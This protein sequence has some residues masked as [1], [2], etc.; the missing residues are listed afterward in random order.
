MSR[1]LERIVTEDGSH[2]LYIPSM[3]ETYHSTH[4]AIQESQHVFVRHG[5]EN[6][7]GLTADDL[8]VFEVGFGTGLNA[9]LTAAWAA[10]NGLTV[11]MTSIE[12]YPVEEEIWNNL[13]YPEQLDQPEAGAWWNA[14]HSSAWNEE[15][16][17]HEHFYLTKLH[18]KLEDYSTHSAFADVI[19][20]DA[21][22]PG[23]QSAMWT[24][25][26]LKKTLTCL[27][28]GGCL[29]TYCAQGQFKRDLAALGL[30]VEPLTGPP[31]KKEMTRGVKKTTESF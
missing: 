7:A 12:A 22:A 17:I 6:M 20:F 25:E 11:H 24:P 1:D 13:N 28:H 3:R 21:F 27:K 2:S 15:I 5:L 4:G 26:M 29:V 14:M 10:K 23:K 8:S 19:Y 31:G 9:L 16:Q 18:Q 30:E